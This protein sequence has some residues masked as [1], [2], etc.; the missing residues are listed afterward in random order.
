MRGLVI[1]DFDSLIEFPE[2]GILSNILIKGEDSNHVLMCL[3]KGSELTKQASSREEAIS[4]CKGIGIL[5]MD[6]EKIR[7]EKGAFLFIPKNTP[8]SIKAEE[9]LAFIISLFGKK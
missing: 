2:E 1:T 8:H 6:H 4:I 7:I 3:S 5:A 9:N